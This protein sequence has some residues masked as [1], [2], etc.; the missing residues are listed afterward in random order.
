[1]APSTL[2]RTDWPFPALVQGV[3][4]VA[5]VLVVG[6]AALL[7]RLR[8]AAVGASFREWRKALV[9]AGIFA[10]CTAVPLTLY[11][12]W[13]AWSGG[14]LATARL[15]PREAVWLGLTRGLLTPVAAEI[16]YRGVLQSMLAYGWRSELAAFGLR[17]PLAAVAAGV[18]YG[19]DG[20]GATL[21]PP[22]A[23][24]FAVGPFLAAALLG[25]VYGVLFARSR[26]LLAPLLAHVFL[27]GT[28]VAN[29]LFQGYRPPG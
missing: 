20:W 9:D 18:L 17:L 8:L 14:G 11:L 24:S 15:D 23:A 5:V 21:L 2:L 22:Q 7:G 6:I 28:Y 19:L 1:V 26:C 4:L 3:R 12:W 10:A 27:T 13:I 25:T 29:L 16:V